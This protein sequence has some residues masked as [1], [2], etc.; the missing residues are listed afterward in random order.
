MSRDGD[1]CGNGGSVDED[2]S[3]YQRLNFRSG[4]PRKYAFPRSHAAWKAQPGTRCDAHAVP[5]Y[6]SILP[7]S[8]VAVKG[9]CFCVSQHKD[10]IY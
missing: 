1:D 7:N 9:I 6:G 10:M 5:Y 2:I 8:I 4:C 3:Q